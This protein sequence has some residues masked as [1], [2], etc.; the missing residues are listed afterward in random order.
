MDQRNRVLIIGLISVLIVV[1]IGTGLWLFYWNAPTECG[2]G[3]SNYM[4]LMRARNF[5]SGV[6]EAELWSN[7]YEVLPYRINVVWDSPDISAIA[8]LEYLIFNCGYSQADLD[9]YFSDDNF[10]NIMLIDYENPQKTNQC[11]I[12]GLRLYEFRAQFQGDDYLLSQWAKSDGEKRVAAF[13][14]VFPAD[15][16]E[17]MRSYAEQIFPELPAC[18]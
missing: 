3:D 10:Y 11:Q 6:F 9:E 14:L 5:S 4:D 8:I 17:R 1:L 13:F 16:S 18:P 2:T 15:Q 12:D 7:S